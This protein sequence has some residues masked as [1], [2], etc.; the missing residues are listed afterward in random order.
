M[1][2]LYGVL[3]VTAG[4]CGIECEAYRRATTKWRLAYG[5]TAHRKF[6][7]LLDARKN[8]TRH[9]LMALNWF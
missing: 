6:H 3:H 7:P 9:R 1:G 5:L 2:E 8:N 4:V